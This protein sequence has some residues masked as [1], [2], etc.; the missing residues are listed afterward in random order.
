MVTAVAEAK[1]GRAVVWSAGTDTL[2]SKLYAWD[3][4]TGKQVRFRV[5]TLLAHC[6]DYSLAFRLAI[7]STGAQ[8]PTQAHA[9]GA[10]RWDILRTYDSPKP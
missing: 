5:L 8:R 2:P 7:S 1:G 4:D 9:S 3:G 10:V 6:A